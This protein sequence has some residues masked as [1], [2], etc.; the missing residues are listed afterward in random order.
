[1]GLCS[2]SRVRLTSHSMKSLE[3]LSSSEQELLRDAVK[4]RL[5]IGCVWEV[6]LMVQKSEI[7]KPV[8]MVNIPIWYTKINVEPK[9]HL[10]EKETHLPNLHFG[11]PC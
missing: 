4:Q 2:A 3:E 10:I 9:N 7:W 5:G 1:M 11:V 8:D 6:L